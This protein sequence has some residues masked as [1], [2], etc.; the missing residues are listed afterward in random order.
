MI[1][2]RFATTEQVYKYT[3]TK[4]GISK[5]DYTDFAGSTLQP[6]G[7]FSYTK[8]VAL[9]MGRY[10]Y[11]TANNFVM[12]MRIQPNV[13]TYGNLTGD[14]VVGSLTRELPNGWLLQF[15]S[16]LAFLPDKTV[17]EG[18]GGIKPKKFLEAHR[19]RLMAI[20]NC[21][22]LLNSLYYS[23]LAFLCLLKK[24]CLL[25]TAFTPKA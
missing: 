22:H 8:P 5:D 18:S 24:M 2:Q 1:A 19:E 7:A 20:C 25:R 16:G 4:I 6:T 14:G 12:M 23:G 17:I 10:T 3:R 21:R 15:P 9:L 11:S 13:T